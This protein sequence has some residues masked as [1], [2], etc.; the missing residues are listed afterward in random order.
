MLVSVIVP[1]HG[2]RDLKI[3]LDSL[4]NSTYKD[5]DVRIINRG[6]E[7]SVQRNMGIVE[8]AGSNAFLILDSDQSVSPALIAECVSLVEQGFSCV[9]IPE[10]IVVKSFFGKIRAFEREFYTGTAVD[11]PRFVT[12]KACPMFNPELSGPED[13]E[14]SYRIHGIRATSRNPL[15]HHDDIGFWDYM[16]KKKY[17][18][19]SMKRYAELCPD[20]PCLKIKYRCFQ[21]FVENGKWK[22][23]VQHPILTLGIIFVLFCRGIIYYLYKSR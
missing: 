21:I 23:L 18:T 16:A 7:R 10:I 11:V 19:K 1:T 12:K 9:Y 4:E 8:A 22:K 2:N 17:Y 3:L 15:Y 14:W 20:D 13:A 5:L 6:K